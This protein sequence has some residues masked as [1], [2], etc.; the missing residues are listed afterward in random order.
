MKKRKRPLK[1]RPRP[2][3]DKALAGLTPYDGVLPGTVLKPLLR[4][5]LDKR[6][7]V[8]KYAKLVDAHLR[9]TRQLSL[10]P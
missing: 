5:L 7:L 4:E 10:F 3:T 2:I 6:K 9:S 8:R 1:Q